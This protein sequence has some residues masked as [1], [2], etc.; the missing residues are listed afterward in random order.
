LTTQ[1]SIS[2]IKP[3]SQ[4]KAK[5]G[6]EYAG[7]KKTELYPFQSSDQ[8]SSRG[9]QSTLP[10]QESQI[11]KKISKNMKKIYKKE[12][13]SIKLLNTKARKRCN[14]DFDRGNETRD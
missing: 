4:Q 13:G 10:G 5:K 14:A 2:L 11:S 8:I 6:P 3:A 9:F 7:Q 12:C 1:A